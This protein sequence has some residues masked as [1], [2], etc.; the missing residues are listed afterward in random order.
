[1]ATRRSCPSEEED[2]DVNGKKRPNAGEDEGKHKKNGCG[3]VES[4]SPQVDD[5][6]SWGGPKTINLRRNSQGFG[7][8]LRHFIVYPPESAVHTN[9]KDEENGN[10][11]C[12]YDVHLFSL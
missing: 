5:M 1:M 3:Q 11:G 4:T 9:M 2:G 7:F 6:F 12:E 10:K 8:T